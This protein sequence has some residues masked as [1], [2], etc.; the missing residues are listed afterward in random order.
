MV[1]L[2]VGR[3]NGTQDECNIRTLCQD[4]DEPLKIQFST[5]KIRPGMPK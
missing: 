4:A 3:K 1:T 2:F 5:K